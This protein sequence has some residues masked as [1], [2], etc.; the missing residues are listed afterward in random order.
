MLTPSKHLHADVRSH[1]ETRKSIVSVRSLCRDFVRPNGTVVTVLEGINLDIY[2]NEFLAI[3]GTSGSGKSTMLRCLAGLLKPTRGT[4]TFAEPEDPEDPLLS[5]VFQSFAL[6]PWL[7]V[8]ENVE[9][10]VRKLPKNERNARVDDILELVGLASYDGVYPRELSGGMKQRVSLARAMVGE[11]MVLFLDEPFSALDPLTSESLRAE[12]G[13]LWM[14]ADRKIRSAVLVTHSLDEA[15]QLADRVIILQANPGSIYRV[16]EVN[17]PR[18]RNPNS[19]E[20]RLLE[21]ELER[22]FGELQLGRMLFEHEE[23]HHPPHLPA[24]SAIPSVEQ[25]QGGAQ[26][27]TQANASESSTLSGMDRPRRVKPII[28]TSLVLVEGLL[29]RLAE[30]EIGMD[31]YDLADE[32]GQSVDHVIPAVASGELLG[33]LYTPGTRLVLTETGRSFAKE[34]DTMLRR[35]VLKNACL[36]LPL[37]ASI[38]ELVKGT[39]GQG[40]EKSIALE[41]IVMMLPFEDPDLQFEA[42]LKWCRHVNLLSY[43][44]AK[45]LLYAED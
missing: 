7:T 17:L 31:L 9:I 12:I 41:Q 33:L 2:D 39:Q 8:R 26:T 23:D 27:P 22:L 10:A 5:F 28:N 16:F 32:L 45:S 18:P 1:R 43:D 30:E 36:N 3:L 15:M 25:A 4:V 35:A 38:Y 6:F 34:Q 42:L 40:L 37:V 21:A 13:R 44:A 11:P 19:E 14:Q 29:T 20:F 24:A